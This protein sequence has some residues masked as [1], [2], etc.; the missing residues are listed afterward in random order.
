MRF[1]SNNDP[2]IQ[3]V[4]QFDANERG[5]T[6]R[7]VWGRV[8]DNKFHL[9]S[10][11]TGMFARPLGYEVNLSSSDRESPE[12]GRMSQILMKSERDLGAMASFDVRRN[13]HP[14]K[15][16][17]VDAAVFNGQ[18]INASGEFDNTKDV[19]SRISLKPFPLSKNL[20]IS[21]GTSLLYGGLQNNTAYYYTTQD[22]SGIKKVM[23]DSSLNNI[24]SLSPR[25]YYGADLQLKLKKKVGFTEIR[26]E[27]LKGQQTGTA[28]S[29]ETPTALLNGN[30]GFYNRNFN[31]AYFYLV[32]NIFSENHQLVLKY[33]WYDPNTNVKKL[34]IGLPGSGFTAADIKYT[35]IGLGY[36]YL[37]GPNVKGVL[38]YAHV[39]NEKTLLP[40]FTQDVK[41][42]VLT[43]RLQFRF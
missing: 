19:V 17:K 23:V 21:G 4:F 20:T 33:D 34:E 39:R 26:G 31:G 30:D 11:T 14:L 5:F 6:V 13:K 9:F 28:I 8:F 38:Y 22:E 3:F 43:L 40:E 42:D 41:D 2:G 12:R 27:F 25:R 24:G 35:T 7:D 16:I 29:S 10:F 18:G 37:I 36:Q 15:Y 1:N 32:H